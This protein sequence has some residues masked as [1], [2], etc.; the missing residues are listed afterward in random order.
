LRHAATAELADLGGVLHQFG[1]HPTDH[2]SDGPFG[3]V[4]PRERRG[5]V[6]V[7]VGEVFQYLLGSNN[8]S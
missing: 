1:V 7:S 8:L 3:V 6:E 2:V 5:D 4:V